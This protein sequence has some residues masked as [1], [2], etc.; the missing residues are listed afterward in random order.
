M[1]IFALA[2]LAQTLQ[3]LTPLDAQATLDAARTQ[4]TDV[5]RRD[6]ATARADRMTATASAP[7]ATQPP[8]R[9]PEPT[10]TIV[11]ASATPTPTPPPA[12]PTEVAP[13][14]TQEHGSAPAVTPAQPVSERVIGV[15][16]LSILALASF[17]LL[18]WR[19]S[20]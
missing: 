17:G 3:P 7:T 19:L 6:A 12:T 9:T 8:T 13:A 5:S 20:R 11:P 2:V 15:G 16:L 4:A 18:I 14:R 10:A 1:I